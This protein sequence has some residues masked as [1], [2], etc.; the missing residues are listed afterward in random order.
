MA[1]ISKLLSLI[2][3]VPRTIDFSNAANVFEFGG[4]GIQ[5]DGSTSGHIVIAA[6]A[7]TSTYSLILPAAQAAS[8]G[9]V[10]SNDG[11]GQLSWSS[12]SAGSVTSVALS[13]PSIFNVTGSPVTSSG[14][15]SATFNTQTAN[16]VFAGPASGG[17]AAPTFRALVSAD[18]PNN[19]ANTTGTASNVTG[20]VALI[21]GG[22]GT[23]AASANAAFNALSPMTTAGDIIYENATPAA[24]RLAIGSS[25]QVLTV[26]AGLPVWSTPPTPTAYVS[27]VALADSTNIFNITGS[28]ITSSGT[29]TLSSLKS[30]AAN[31]FFAGPN[32][33]SGAPTFRTIVAADLPSLS[34][35]YL[36]LAGGTMSGAIDMGS[37]KI[38]SLANGTASGDAVN[39][40][41]LDT[42]L[43]KALAQNHIFVGSAG[44]VATDV[45]MSGEASI[46]ASGAVTLSNAA[47]IAKVLTGYAAAAGTVSAS[48]SILVAIEKID[49]NDAL[50]LPLAGGTMSGNIA[51]GGNKVTGLGAPT[52]NGD[53]LRYDQLGAVNGIATLDGS[54]K[55]PLSQLPASVMEYKG[56]WDASTNTP[57]LAD[58]T[59]VAGY[60]YRVSV[61]G[62]QDL[63]SGPETYFV[64]DFVIYNG[65]IWQRSPLADGVVSVNGATG[66][67]I[68]NAI[69]Q[70]TGDVTTSAASGSQSEA[71]TV[72]KIQ[73]TTVSGTTGSGNVVFSNAPTFTGLLSGSSASFSSTI[74]ASNFS[75]S[76]SGTNTGDQTIT[77]TGDVTGS[78]TG[79]FATTI[80]ANAVTTTKINNAAVTAAK[81]G[82]VT[83]GVT[84]DQAGSGSTLEIKAGGV[85]E[86]QIN[87]SALSASGALTGGSGTKLSVSVDGT[88]VAISGNQLVA[89]AAPSVQKTVIAGQ[90]F[91][92]NTTYALR[93]GN[94]GQ[95]ETVDR[96]YA[97]DMDTATWDKFW[98][99]GM[100]NSTS[101]KTAGDPILM[102]VEGHLAL[103]SSDSNFAAGDRGLPVW[104][105]NAG[106][107]AGNS[108]GASPG[109]GNA[110]FKL[111]IVEAVNSI[112]VDGQMMGVN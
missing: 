8:A 91:S 103:G 60:M 63:G 40:S 33:S 110:S 38:T 97:A 28:P 77:L 36:A 52:T 73:G 21:N 84:L 72:A 98:A 26:S 58:G 1:N 56:A 35:I 95:G 50:K 31:S 76:S 29:L 93:W 88:T 87:S 51:M 96:V 68:V 47:V 64:G 67:V 12:P 20:I 6:S 85:T 66:A 106:A 80:A 107:F 55:I 109:A 89:L 111:G 57:T 5:F 92:A 48:D 14:T 41:Q 108:T 44:G 42:K 18:I 62:T 45:A 30:Q 101:A 99:I 9:Y 2:N 13:L 61:A 23:A 112:W 86:T 104:L 37:N 17:A 10:L 78:G 46:V 79:S 71:A 82:T 19:A 65:T 53:A 83:D 43:D 25:G 4:G 54:G 15:L 34:G 27:S 39:F 11:T 90:S 100:F 70:L 81:L 16:F 105:A 24:A 69:N 102:T 59:G 74:A 94:P 3:G 75:G 49:G 7:V 32:G 22:T